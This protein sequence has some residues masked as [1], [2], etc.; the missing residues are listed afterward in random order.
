M[1]GL[2]R[3]PNSNQKT[4]RRGA[5]GWPGLKCVTKGEKSL[6]TDLE[7][8]T[9]SVWE[10][11]PP[12]LHK[13][14]EALLHP[15]AIRR[16]RESLIARFKRIGVGQHASLRSADFSIWSSKKSDFLSSRLIQAQVA[17]WVRH[18]GLF[19]KHAEAFVRALDWKRS[20][21]VFK[22][23]RF[24]LSEPH[25][26]G[27]AVVYV[28]LIDSTAWFYKARSGKHEDAWAKIVAAINREGF[29]PSLAA[30]SVVAKRDHC[31]MGAISERACRSE[32]ETKRFWVRTGALLYLAHTL[33]AVDLN[34]ANILAN[35]EQPVVIDCETFL[36]P[37]VNLPA[38]A[39]DQ[40]N[41]I[42]RTG[43]VCT[44]KD[45]RISFIARLFANH[46]V[47]PRNHCVPRVSVAER[48]VAGFEAMHEFLCVPRPTV[49]EA[50]TKLGALPTRIIYRPTN[51]YMQL[52][53]ES[54]APGL[55]GSEA[56][57]RWYLRTRLDDGLCA[58][59]VM[60]SEVE[61]L[62]LGDIPLFRGKPARPRFFLS[63][64]EKG[65]V[66]T[67]LKASLRGLS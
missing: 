50:F 62:L 4:A 13:R 3:Q 10:K 49:R 55:I 25:R 16:L 57:R 58:K 53:R 52:L 5:C 18:L 19:L 30:A 36:H 20:Q 51:F 45:D 67:E 32:R 47:A 9:W 54:L 43:M 1:D 42:L 2:E 24:D 41:S 14:M 38:G 29:V 26:G 35:G 56:A 23:I 7:G 40:P 12:V 17:N 15:A 11:L 63:A 33:R 31:W 46:G 34:A 66:T 21:P 61:Q 65:R 37:H 22:A 60:Q 6:K 39:L 48:I 59:G 8:L 64:R 28:Q 44:G 27:R